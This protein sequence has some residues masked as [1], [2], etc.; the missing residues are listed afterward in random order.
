MT[1]AGSK[2]VYIWEELC[3]PILI[4]VCVHTSIPLLPDMSCLTMVGTSFFV[5]LFVS[6]F[7]A[8]TCTVTYSTKAHRG[9]KCNG[10]RAGPRG[11]I[12]NE[13][14]LSS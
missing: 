1:Q 14:S 3:L 12:M 6:L 11:M 5:C 2:L 13:R 9:P 10:H 7:S 4:Q 8:V